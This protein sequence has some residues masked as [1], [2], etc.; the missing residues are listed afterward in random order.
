MEQRNWFLERLGPRVIALFA[1]SS[2]A[3]MLLCIWMTY[4]LT[5]GTMNSWG[6]VMVPVLWTYSSLCAAV[7]A[8][9]MLG[10]KYSD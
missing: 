8:G 1:L 5:V 4:S 10:L 3:A 9:A 7:P 6:W 2:M